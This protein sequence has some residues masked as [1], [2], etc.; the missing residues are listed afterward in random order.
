MNHYIR[1]LR[2][3]S[4][5]FLESIGI[6]NAWAV[7]TQSL[8]ALIFIFLLS[9]AIGKLGKLIMQKYIPILVRNT[10]TNWDDKLFENKF[11]EILSYY[12]FGIV[13][14]WIDI[15]IASDT[16]RKFINTITG[17]YFTIITVMLINALL[18]TAYDIYK[19]RRPNDKANLK[20][21][22][23]LIK[24]L[25]FSFGG[26][27]IISFFA[28]KGFLVIL[29]GLGAMATI[30]LIVYKDTIMGF[31]AGIS[32]STNKMVEV[33]DWISVP[34]H[35][36]DG[37]VIDIG[38]NTVKVQNFDK[39]ITTIPP[40]N[41]VSEAFTNWRGMR[42][43]GGRRIKRSIN[44]DIDSI[45][46][47]S[48]KEIEKFGNFKLLKDYI[49]EKKKAIVKANKGVEEYYNQR[50]LTN[51]GT[52]KKYLE[53]YLL[54]SDFV[55]PDMTFIVRQ[56]QSN[57]KGLPIEVYFFCTEQTWAKY[58]QIQSDIFDHFFAIAPEFGLQI[59]QT[60]SGR[61]LKSTIQYSFNKT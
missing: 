20:I 44:I 50:R 17:T 16:M 30:L 37:T 54:A 49:N 59:F 25:V 56:L 6:S 29:K 33:G 31:V 53:N 9:Y 40:Y 10:K 58:E 32:L 11:F 34:K 48:P 24:V 28:N 35:D 36:A 41:L 13:F 21:Y 7:F 46:F 8:L 26:I 60:V 3:L 14:F 57:E 19:E 51:I 2:E 43:S 12:L 23:Q 15:L 61:S 4:I 45:H 55:H 22:L 38:L 1:T 27:I 52:F 47:L 39:T 42:Q 18:N 5:S